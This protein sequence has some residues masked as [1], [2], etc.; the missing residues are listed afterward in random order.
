MNKDF[1][2]VMPLTT[3]TYMFV[4]RKPL[5]VMFGDER[6]EA[7]TWREVYSVII[8]RCN[9]DP[10]CHDMLMY[11][12]NKASGKVRMFLSDKPDNMSC[13]LKIDEDLYGEIHYGSATLMHILCIRILEPA[14]LDYSKI[15]IVMKSRC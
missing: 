1:K 4:G 11:L 6:V 2:I 9:S 5:A 13:S 15:S 12:R 10:R 8:G 3:A 7:K 14:H